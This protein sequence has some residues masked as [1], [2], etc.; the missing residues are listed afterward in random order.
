[1]PLLFA[2]LGLVFGSYALG[3]RAAASA[4]PAARVGY[5]MG[6]GMGP[7]FGRGLG[8]GP[9]A[10]PPR[11]YQGDSVFSLPQRRWGQVECLAQCPGGGCHYGVR[12]PGGR[13]VV[14]AEHE[15]VR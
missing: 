9:G 1:M 10:R 4:P 14:L 5:G 8:L 3:R 15:I 13:A 6:Y 7:G 11:Y 12:F 2:I